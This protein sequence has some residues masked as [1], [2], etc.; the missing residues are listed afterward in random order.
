MSELADFI[1]ARICEEER[2]CQA[3]LDAPVPGAEELLSAGRL[4]LHCAARRK[5]LALHEIHVVDAG[6]DAMIDGES[7]SCR[8]GQNE[9]DFVCPTLRLLALPYFDHP[10]FKDHWQIPSD[11]TRHD[12]ARMK[13]SC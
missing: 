10:D 4:L 9:R 7:G 2:A 6:W 8:A 11:F 1:L 5:V 13:L 12:S 3:R